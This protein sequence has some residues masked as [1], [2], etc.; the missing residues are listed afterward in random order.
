M[1]GR[2]LLAE[3]KG[4]YGL[5]GCN[6]D[7]SYEKLRPYKHLGLVN[8][9]FCNKLPSL[10]KGDDVRSAVIQKVTNEKLSI[11]NT[12]LYSFTTYL[13]FRKL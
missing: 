9:F 13:E 6:G 7:E 11:W 10:S 2:K 8:M 4:V 1:F 12:E 5:R 3:C